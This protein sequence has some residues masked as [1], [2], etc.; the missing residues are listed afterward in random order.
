M[1][2]SASG[3]ILWPCAPQCTLDDEEAEEGEEV[4]D[5]DNTYIVFTMFQVP[6]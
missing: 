4:Q 6:F 5:E 3:Q 2:L 1:Y